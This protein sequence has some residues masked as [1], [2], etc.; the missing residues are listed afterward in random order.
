MNSTPLSVIGL[1]FG[2]MLI[3]FNKPL[4]RYAVKQNKLLFG[5]W[6]N[7]FEGMT[8]SIGVIVGVALIAFSLAALF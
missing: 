4:S 2:V 6:F 8:R 1:V 7:E 3:I 5:E